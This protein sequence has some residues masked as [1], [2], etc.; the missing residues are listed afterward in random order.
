MLTSCLSLT[1]F[2]AEFQ[3]NTFG[4]RVSVEHILTSCFSLTHFDVVF[5]F[6]IFGRRVSV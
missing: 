2:D 1:H 6:N 3:F 4:R 5:Q